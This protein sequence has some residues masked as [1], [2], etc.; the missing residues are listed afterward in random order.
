MTRMF[1]V[2]CSRWLLSFGYKSSPL[3]T[4]FLNLRDCVT[5]MPLHVP[6]RAVREWEKK[7][8]QLRLQRKCVSLSK[9]V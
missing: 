1:L 9:L 4:L 6:R 7:T 3:Y 5:H 2:F 8:H